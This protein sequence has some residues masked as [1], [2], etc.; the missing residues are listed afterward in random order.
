MMN[1]KEY[2]DKA[3]RTQAPDMTNDDKLRHA[4]FGLAS[5]A[6]EVAGLMQ[7]RYQGHDLNIDHMVKEL[8]DCLWMIA[9]ACDAVGITMDDV[10]QTNILK[11]IE[12][13]PDGFTAEKSLHRKD[14]DI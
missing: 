14:G 10:A 4:V 11:L 5:E 9:E 7:K 1:F 3:R 13:Y 2:Q 12:R 8:G 6:G